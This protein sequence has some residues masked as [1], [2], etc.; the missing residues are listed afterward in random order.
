MKLLKHRIVESLSDQPGQTDA[1]LAI[2]LNE[3]RQLINRTLY[4]ELSA[5]TRR[6]DN[7]RWYAL[8]D[9]ERAEILSTLVARTSF[10]HLRNQNLFNVEASSEQLQMS[11]NADHRFFRDDFHSLDDQGQRTVLRL[12]ETLGVAM[13]HK[14][15][16]QAVLD[17]L[18]S[19]W[20]EVLNQRV[21]SEKLAG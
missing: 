17:D 9:T 20:S 3:S 14:F 8:T 11:L 19:E 21:Q 1:E 13:S 4:L 2:S 6:D 7:L 10:D 18:I 5:Q 12:L 16:N 15:Q